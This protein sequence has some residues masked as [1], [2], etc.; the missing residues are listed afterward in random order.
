MVFS[1]WSVPKHLVVLPVVRS[2]KWCW[3]NKKKIGLWCKH[4]LTEM[5]KRV[6]KFGKAAWKV[7]K[8]VPAAVWMAIKK[9]P[10]VTWKA[11][12]KILE[13]IKEMG[14]ALWRF[15]TV[16]IPEAVRT[17]SKWAWEGISSLAR[18]VGDIL[19]RLISFLHSVLEGIIT[20]LRNVTP[21]DIWNALCDFL[22]AVFVT[23]ISEI[24]RTGPC[25]LTPSYLI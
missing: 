23:F 8:K 15:L 22:R 5:P 14:K 24:W 3:A 12:K 11:I 10:E 20:F 6:V 13:A 7:T 1:V 25:V 21:R 19:L 4:Q 17:A 9:T 2:C 18:A 16:T